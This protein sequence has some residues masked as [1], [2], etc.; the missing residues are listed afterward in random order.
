M[1][2]AFIDI[3]DLTMKITVRLA[4]GSIKSFDV[5]EELKITKEDLNEHYIDQPGKYAWWG[6]LAEVAKNSMEEAKAAMEREEAE[7]DIRVR[8]EL[9]MDGKKATENLVTRMI[10]QDEKYIQAQQRYFEARKNYGILNMI[11]K[12]FE[13]RMEALISLGANLRS[14][15]ANV[16]LDMK[17]EQVKTMF[18]HK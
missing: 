14:E 12:A 11:H 9:D 2:K 10:K 17:K 13:Q 1:S 6:M 16:D 4:D 18:E 5:Q 15:K 3:D 7:A 8:K